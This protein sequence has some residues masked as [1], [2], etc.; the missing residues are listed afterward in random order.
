MDNT[1]TNIQKE[2]ERIL[3]A[4]SH[5]AFCSLVALGIAYKEG[6]PNTPLTEHL[7][8]VRWLSTAK[9]QK[10]FPK[11]IAVDIAFLLELAKKKGPASKLRE[12]LQYLWKYSSTSMNTPSDLLR[13]TNVIE[14]LKEYG[15]QNFTLENQSR[16]NENF[17]TVHLP[18]GFYIEENGLHVVRSNDNNSVISLELRIVGD[19]NLFL[20]LMSQF[21]ISTELTQRGELFHKITLLLY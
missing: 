14:K 1:T 18:N 20:A 21:D 10:R 17:S 9:K 6:L 19:V 12:E 8:L 11:C 13:L 5:L 16:Q 2:P 3:A 7:F 15:W 4:L